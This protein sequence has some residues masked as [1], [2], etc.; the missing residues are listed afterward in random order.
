[1]EGRSNRDRRAESRQ[2]TDVLDRLGGRLQYLTR[3]ID[4]CVCEPCHR[5]HAR[6]LA[7]PTGQRPSRHVRPRR[8]RAEVERKCKVFEHP[9]AKGAELI[10]AR[11]W[12]EPFDELRLPSLTLWRSHETAGSCVGSCG[13]EVAPNDVEGQVD[14]CGHT[15]R[16]EDVAVVDEEAVGQHVDPGGAALK[17]RGPPPGG[18]GPTGVE[19]TPRRGGKRG[20]TDRYP[21]GAPGGGPP[22]GARD[23]APGR[24]AGGP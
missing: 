7:K 18:R 13:A 17:L 1:M 2:A 14:P 5:R 9:I 24:G 16:R 12:H 11:V 10:A 23:R 8:E 19:D 20:G 6:L 21:T 22:D 4:A 15:S 3:S